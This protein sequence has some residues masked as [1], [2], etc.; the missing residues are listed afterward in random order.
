MAAE[1]PLKLDK[2]AIWRVL[3]ANANRARE[4]LRVVEDT[5]RFVMARQDASE[6]VRDLRHRLDAIV[7]HYYSKLLQNRDIEN[8]LGTS[9]ATTPHRSGV[10]A[11]LASNFKRSAEALRVMEEYSRVV[12]PR[13]VR[14]VQAIRY[15]V[16]QWEK[17][18]LS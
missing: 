10:P 7:R 9:N 2:K 5:A 8:D 13:A 6:G 17:K 3:D 12:A 1:K 14:G 15:G 16:Y 18:L 4:G 11:I